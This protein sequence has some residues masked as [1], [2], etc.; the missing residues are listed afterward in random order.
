MSQGENRIPYEQA[1]GMACMV[2]G[3][4]A[5]ICERIQVA[6]SLRRKKVDVGDIELV[7]IEA[8]QVDWTGYPVQHS[9]SIEAVLLAAGYKLLKNGEKF[10]QVDLGGIVLDL[11]IT[12]PECWGVIFLIR[13]GCAEFARQMVTRRSQGGMMPNHLKVMDGRVWRDGK[14]LETPEEDCIFRLW[15]MEYIQ[16]EDRK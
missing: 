11:F 2:V 6:G 12:T 15:G 7:C 10:K 5:P 1:L 16:P 4:L 14:E 8:P 3:M 13:T 9:Q